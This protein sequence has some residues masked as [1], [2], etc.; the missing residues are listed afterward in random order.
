VIRKNQRECGQVR[1]LCA[2]FDIQ[3]YVAGSVLFEMG[4]TKILCSVTIQNGVP[5][6]L[7]GKDKGWLTAEYAMLPGAT[8]SRT[9]R[10]VNNIRR[11]GRSVEISRIIGRSVRPMVGLGLIGERTIYLDCDV[12]QADG[13]TRTASISAC[14]IAL[15]IAQNKLLKEGKIHGPILQEDFASV[16]V[17][18]IGQ[19]V[20][21]DIDCAEDNRVDADLNFVFARSGAI[22]E[23]QGSAEG[24]P[25]ERALFDQACDVAWC[26]AKEIFDF[27]D[28][29]AL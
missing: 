4:N 23:V 13:G 20:L 2:T 9:T 22:I 29:L 25:L 12:I 17:G 19:E 27:Y 16:A 28:S 14:C 11:S 7:R 26:G 3:Q 15:K 1:A 10:D 6:F 21:L 5:R 18:I 24:Q 8:Q